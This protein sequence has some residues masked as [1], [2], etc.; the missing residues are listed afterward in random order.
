MLAKWGLPQLL[1]VRPLNLVNYKKIFGEILR[2]KCYNVADETAKGWQ[3]NT[4]ANCT[5]G[6]LQCDRLDS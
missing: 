2:G 4:R 6:G 1:K 5:S 3:L